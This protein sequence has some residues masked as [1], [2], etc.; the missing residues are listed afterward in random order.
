MRIYATVPIRA[1]SSRAIRQ[2][3]W[4]QCRIASQRSLPGRFR[5]FIVATA[6]DEKWLCHSWIDR[7]C[8]GVIAVS[9]AYFAPVLLSMLLK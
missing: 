7:A 6:W 2:P 8:L 5:R 1:S 3:R 9:A 4:V